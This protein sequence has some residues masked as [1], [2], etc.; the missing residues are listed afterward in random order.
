LDNATRS[1]T[2]EGF[3]KILKAFYETWEQLSNGVKNGEQFFE[4]IGLK[5]K[6]SE[7]EISKKMDILELDK[8]DE[9]FE[10]LPADKREKLLHDAEAAL[11]IDTTESD[12]VPPS[13]PSSSEKKG[14]S[15]NTYANAVSG[16]NAF[17]GKNKKWIGKGKTVSLASFLYTALFVYLCV[18][19]CFGLVF[20][21]APMLCHRSSKPH[22]VRFMRE[23]S[24]CGKIINFLERNMSKESIDIFRPNV[25]Q[26]S[27]E[28]WR[29]L[30]AKQTVDYRTDFLGYQHK[31][32]A[33]QRFIKVTPEECKS[34]KNF[35]SCEFGPLV[36]GN[37]DEWHTGNKLD[38]DFSW[39]KVGWQKA[40]AVNCFLSKSILV[41]EPGKNSLNSPV[42][43]VS[44]CEF[45]ARECSLKNGGAL[46]WDLKKDVNGLY[47]SR[48]CTFERVGHFEGNYSKGVWYSNDM[49]RSLIFEENSMKVESCGKNLRVSNTGLAITENDYEIIMNKRKNFRVKREENVIRDDEVKV[50]ELLSRLQAEAVFQD[51]QIRSAIGNMVN[52]LCETINARDASKQ[53]SYF[54][55][56]LFVREK[57]GNSFLQAEWV[58]PLTL[59]FWPC[60]AVNYTFSGVQDGRCF[61]DIPVNI[62]IN[63]NKLQAFMDPRT[64]IIKA[65]SDETDCEAY[66]FIAFSI[67][68]QVFR[69]DQWSGEVSQIA[70]KEIRV[71]QIKTDSV[72]G[73]PQF[74]LHVFV[75]D[76][77]NNLT[78]H[79]ID[80]LQLLHS[81]L[82][83]RA[84][85]NRP[86]EEK[87]FWPNNE[88][89]WTWTEVFSGLDYW[90]YVE[91]LVC[92]VVMG[93]IIYQIWLWRNKKMVKKMLKEDLAKNVSLQN[94]Q[95][96]NFVL[97]GSVAAD[98]T[99]CEM[100]PEANDEPIRK[101]PKSR[102]RRI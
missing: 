21:Q 61:M 3:R 77:L 32:P 4:I 20:S 5:I 46:I 43:D 60:S 39:W 88:N 42:E 93:K 44:H 2:T 27:F 71:E 92:M 78:E 8:K 67:G 22:L 95:S 31:R 45:N 63:G 19:L 97:K 50:S 75:K 55:A 68:K 11:M 57:F 52:M 56:T 49:Q 81:S 48:G 91:R 41:G 24:K 51:K 65:S 58:D 74:E 94:L 40:I 101:M 86:V 29:C 33:E 87:G 38:L 26:F 10:K 35:K 90:E 76:A 99:K 34:W 62:S 70:E 69:I 79:Q 14:E 1:V 23:E 47:D 6:E 64:L 28:G 36:H 84:L 30:V 73:L 72:S 100:D 53:L 37:E 80:F 12:D 7:A 66:R 96:S 18:L 102:P 82:G 83:Q 85:D 9:E 59:E 17:S 16:K 25:G 98:E 13:V 89:K 15:V 54:D